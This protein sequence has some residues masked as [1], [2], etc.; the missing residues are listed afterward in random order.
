MLLLTV[1]A[2]FYLAVSA[3]NMASA[4]NLSSYSET[5]YSY[6]S[7]GYLLH[8]NSPML[9]VEGV[10]LKSDATLQVLEGAKAEASQTSQE[11]SI[12]GPDA[13][14]SSSASQ[15]TGPLEY[16][17]VS[18][19][20]ISTIAERF[21]ISTE[22]VLWA[23]NLSNANFIK[24]GQSLLILPVDGI[25]YSVAKGDTL[26]SLAIKYGVSTED[27]LGYP[28]NDLPDANALSIGQE[29]IIPGGRPVVRAAAS[30]SSRGG[31][32]SVGEASSGAAAAAPSS[33][34]SG[35]FIWPNAGLITQYFG[36][37]HD[38]LDIAAPYGTAIVAADGG[39]V[40]DEQRLGW[41]LGS[42]ITIDHGNGYATTYSHMSVFAVGPGERVSQG[43]MIGRIGMTGLTTGPHNH[44]MVRRNGVPI[45][46]LG[47]LP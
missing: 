11:Q 28:G 40:V 5:S 46:P 38:A 12:A 3:R 10:S 41:G 47:V 13:S 44:F 37:S 23:N 17:V 29:L 45:D 43:E 39:V 6:N 30:T 42:Y 27:I 14:P 16:E 4:A 8:P 22:T 9:V 7:E 15:R 36:A 33:P 21:G 35:R 2:A 18:G 31:T 26:L 25:S 1:V 34:P 19:D 24:D 20:T 32:R